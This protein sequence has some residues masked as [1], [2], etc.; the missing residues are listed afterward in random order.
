MPAVFI[1]EILK[2]HTASF[3]LA[4]NLFLLAMHSSVSLFS[5]MSYVHNPC[6][7]MKWPFA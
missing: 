4:V 5:I 1:C 7:F 3:Y 2:R 6:V